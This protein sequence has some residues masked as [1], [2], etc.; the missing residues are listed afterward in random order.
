MARPKTTVAPLAIPSEPSALDKLVGAAVVTSFISIWLLSV[1]SPFILVLSIKS[2]YTAVAAL[3]VAITIASYLPWSHGPVSRS[4]Q[5]VLNRYHG[6]YY[7]S[8]TIVYES[9]DDSGDDNA[10]NGAASDLPSP[11]DPQTFFAVHPHGAF[12]IGWAFLF[13][14]PELAH[15]R[16]CFAPALFASPFFRLFSRCAGW[17]GS[18]ARPAMNSHL[19]D[20]E[21]V[22]LPP[23][24]FEE[25]TL[26]STDHDRVFIK[27]RTGFMKLC[28]RHGVPRVRPVYVFGER[29]LFWNVQGLWGPRLALN[30]FG[31]PTILVWGRWFF[32]LLPRCDADIRVVIGRSLKLP[33]RIEKPT[34]EEVALWHGK[35]MAELRRLFDDHKEDALGAEAAKTAKLEIW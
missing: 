27:R 5:H 8:L 20:G 1:A 7:R 32:P 21:S 11:A 29:D 31:L 4:V 18:A 9:D 13:A 6:C 25:A 2:G 22:A 10:K 26:T 14:S 15:V 30:R 17:P 12:C 35:Y 23:G 28:L 19:R 34:K 33:P 24:G 16:F 3:I